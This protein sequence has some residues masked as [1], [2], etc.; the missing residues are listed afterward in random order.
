MSDT[1]NVTESI[2][3]AIAKQEQELLERIHASEEEAQGIIEKARADAREYQQ[4]QEAVLAAEMA[5]LRRESEEVRLREFDATVGA[6]EAK[7][8]EVRE[9]AL[10]RVPEMA[11]EV[12]TLFLPRASG[13]T[14]T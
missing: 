1:S 8:V 2:L 10:L 9:A 13:E 7:L 5:R 12:L 3:P 6:A 14:R 11:K 4:E